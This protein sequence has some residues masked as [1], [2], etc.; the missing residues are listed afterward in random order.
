ML[1]EPLIFDLLAQRRV[2]MGLANA[3]VI[4]LI[5]LQARPLLGGATALLGSFFIALSPFVLADARTMRGDALL[6][7][8]M[9]LS[10]LL[11]LN[12]LHHP[13]WYRL[14]LSGVAFG[15]A[16]LTKITALPLAGFIGLAILAH[17]LYHTERSWPARLGQ[18]AM[19]LLVGGLVTAATFFALW[20]ALWVAPLE[21]LEFMRGYAASSIDGR[22]NFFWGELTTDQQIMLFYPNAFLFRANPVVVLGVAVITI[23]ALTS[24][25]YWLTNKTSRR[26]ALTEK[27][28]EIWRMP[29]VARFTLLALGVYSVIYGLV[30]TYGALKRD[31]YLMPV[32]PAILFIAAAGLLWPAG[33]AAERW[34][35]KKLPAL[36]A[37]GRW[38][39]AG[40]A[41][42]LLL[43]LFAVLSTHP[44]YYT[45]WSPLMG[46]GRV[47]M[48]VMMAEGGIDSAAIVQLNQRPNASEETLA[49]LTARDY[50]PAYVGNVER[51]T[52][53]SPWVIADH[54]LVRQYHFQTEKMEPHLMDYL[55]RKTP[56]IVDTIQG[57]TWSWVYPGPAAQHYAGSI[58]DGKAELLGY[59]LSAATAAENQPLN[60]KLFW[61]NHGLQSPEFIVVRLVDADGFIWAESAAYPLPNFSA[62]AE[63]RRAY[64][65]SEAKLNI[66]PGT[67]PGLYFLKMGIAAGQPNQ[68]DIGRFT[69]P[70]N[71]NSL[72]VER[73]ATPAE[74]PASVPIDQQMG[75]ALTLIGAEAL[76]AQV[77]TPQ[78]PQP[79]T[80]FWQVD[81]PL[82]DDIFVSVALLD[83][84]GSDIARWQSRPARGIVPPETWQPGDLLLD[85]HILDLSTADIAQPIR[86]DRYM[87]AVSLR[88]AS[89]QTLGQATLGDIEVSDR[90]RLFEP[91][92]IAQKIEAT[93]GD[94]IAL[95]GFNLAEAPI[96][97]GARFDVTL[98]WQAL[99]PIP[100]DYTVFVQVLNPAGVVVGQHDGVPVDG[101]L[102]TGVWEPG[103]IVPDRHLLEFPAQQPGDYRLI[104]G[105]YNPAT[106]QRLP[107]TGGDGTPLGDFLTLHTLTVAQ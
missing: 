81:G 43:E 34:P 96:T 10:A 70:N 4:L 104:A 103:E 19:T 95:L 8:L 84:A 25:F 11:L 80:L 73:P 31:R 50:E 23:L 65:E 37:N 97:G 36:L 15:L 20:P 87:L 48:N 52:N 68:P 86:P 71:A 56:E 85:P 40:L 92:D 41:L 72:V 88:N 66:P 46:G 61:Q 18:A 74:P 2:V 12:H 69:L 32:F 54:V 35:G 99:Q 60:V 29:V 51:L 47:A 9:L 7:G 78:T 55:R 83:A 57:Y 39:W 91:P 42:V 3:I 53:G 98:V 49:L 107:I 75:N 82:P 5:Y 6:S 24:G 14:I 38:A 102:P 33:W 13:R 44:Y 58:L 27:L 59:N 45:Y 64:V 93:L 16:L 105:M 100:A 76:P 106:G 79:L 28:D 26:I 62:A 1:N 90:L 101:S 63:Q 17:A 94:S 89:G 77:L 21:V 22:L 30:L 67:P